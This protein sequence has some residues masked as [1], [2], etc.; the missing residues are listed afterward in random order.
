MGLGLYYSNL[1]ME[2]NGGFLA[3]PQPDEVSVP[4]EYDGAIV[5]M[6]FGKS[7]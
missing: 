7:S 3:F 4:P 6:V 5:A 2:L 1:A